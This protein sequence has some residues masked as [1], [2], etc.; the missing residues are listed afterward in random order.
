M[1]VERVEWLNRRSYSAISLF[2]GREGRILLRTENGLEDWF[3][4]LEVNFSF[5]FEK[6]I[7]IP[8]H[9]NNHVC[10]ALNALAHNS[11]YDRFECVYAFQLVTQVIE[12]WF[13]FPSLSAFPCI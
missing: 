6:F 4:L 7:T 2:L 8:H 11:T 1:D 10:I 3:E 13:F 5:Y 9:N 12:S